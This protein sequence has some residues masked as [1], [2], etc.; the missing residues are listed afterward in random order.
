MN[1]FFQMQSKT[2]KHQEF[3]NGLATPDGV[4]KAW[5]CILDFGKKKLID[6][7]SLGVSG[8]LSGLTHF[9]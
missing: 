1:H 5:Y 4:N 8:I 6:L 9:S 7:S 2:R 3:E